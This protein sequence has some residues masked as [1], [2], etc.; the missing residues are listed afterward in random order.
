MI[1]RAEAGFAFGKS[2]HTARSFNRRTQG[3]TFC[4]RVLGERVNDDHKRISRDRFADT[5]RGLAGIHKDLAKPCQSRRG[6]I[7]GREENGP[8]TLPARPRHTKKC[9]FFKP[10]AAPQTPSQPPLFLDSCAS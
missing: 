3:V 6:L 2:L 10:Y 8:N 7:P 5:L 4:V 9:P 1:V